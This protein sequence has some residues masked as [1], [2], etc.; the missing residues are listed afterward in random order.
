MSPARRD[1]LVLVALSLALYAPFLGGYWLTDDFVHVE[2]LERATFAAAFTTPDAFGFYRPISRTSL[3]LD[4]K[5]FG[6]IPWIFR[7][8][9]LVLH[10]AVVCAAWY[11]ATML[12]GPGRAA[13]LATLAFVLTPKAHPVAVLWPSARAELLMALFSLLPW[14]PGS[15]GT[16]MVTVDGWRQPARPMRSA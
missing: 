8:N 1:L 9:N 4:L 3:F 5:L 11:V 15:A 6:E 14:R 2:R 13:F 10:L 16:P 7:L 12:I